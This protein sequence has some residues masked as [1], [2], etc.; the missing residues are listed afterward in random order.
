MLK[1]YKKYRD[2]LIILLISL[3]VFL[4]IQ[5][6]RKSNVIRKMNSIS[7]IDHHKYEAWKDS[8]G[9]SH[10]KIKLQDEYITQLTS[11]YRNIIEENSKLLKVKPSDIKQV[12]KITTKTSDSFKSRINKD[13][14]SYSDGYI[15]ITG[16]IQKDSLGGI[17]SGSYIY[18]DTANYIIYYKRTK[19]LGITTKKELTLDVYFNNPNTFI[20]GVTNISLKDYT[21]PKRIGLGIQTGVTYINGSIQPYIGVGI[22]YTLIQI[23]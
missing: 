22:Q 23:L 21:K 4:V 16:T 5:N 1:F 8:L 11:E 17:I 12:T 2:L 6:F 7:K 9:R 10:A 3:G 15:G 18:I 19:F 13:T 14:F 20:T